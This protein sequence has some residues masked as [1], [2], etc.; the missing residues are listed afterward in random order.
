MP[1]VTDVGTGQVRKAGQNNYGRRNLE[2]LTTKDKEHKVSLQKYVSYH[3]SSLTSQNMKAIP[4]EESAT[5]VSPSKE[6]TNLDD[7]INLNGPCTE[8]SIFNVLRSRFTK[9][10]FQVFLKAYNSLINSPAFFRP[11]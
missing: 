7:L 5:T 11:G 10:L 9:N 8:A 4:E 2:E 1:D 3:A 6:D